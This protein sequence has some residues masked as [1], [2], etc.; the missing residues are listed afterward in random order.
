MTASPS[1]S[2]RSQAG[3]ATAGI[4]KMAP[5]NAPVLQGFDYFIG[6]INQ[7][8]CHNMYPRAV[9]TGNTSGLNVNLTR[10]YNIPA[11]PTAA[12]AACMAEPGAFNY[13][14][15]I[16]H[17]HSMAWLKNQD[18]KV[19]VLV[20]LYLIVTSWYSSSTLYQVSYHIQ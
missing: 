1:D 3:Y 15:D 13:T 6:Q 19:R 8:L 4:G 10:N 11:E 16:T 17:E 18:G 7:G 12:R 14:V 2:A 20:G 9:D 5:L